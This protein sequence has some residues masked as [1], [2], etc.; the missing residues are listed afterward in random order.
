VGEAVDVELPV[1]ACSRPLGEGDR[2]VDNVVD[3][4]DDTVP[5]D[6]PEAAGVDADGRPSRGG[7]GRPLGTTDEVTLTLA[8]V[9]SASGV[10]VIAVPVFLFPRTLA[11][12]VFVE[13][14]WLSLASTWPYTSAS[15]SAAVAWP[16]E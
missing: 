14:T 7:W 11:V 4:V 16:R 10:G 13:S 8:M 6:T 1:P 9:S 5:E 2:R 15:A 3:A 12:L